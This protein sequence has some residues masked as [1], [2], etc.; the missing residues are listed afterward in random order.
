[1]AQFTAPFLFTSVDKLDDDERDEWNRRWR[2]FKPEEVACKGTGFLLLD[3]E[4]LDRMQRLRAALGSPIVV[5]SWY[6]SPQHNAAVGSSPFSMHPVG[7]ATDFLV[8][9]TERTQGAIVRLAAELGFTGIGT[10][11]DSGFVHVDT[12]R[13]GLTTWEG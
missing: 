11:P 10:Y 7:R 6:R 1:M 12:R 2:S 4:H 5:T 3:P 8:G 13:G 9:P